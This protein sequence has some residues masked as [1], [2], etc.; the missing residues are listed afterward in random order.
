MR[1]HLR[2]ILVALA[3]AVVAAC[4]G[5]VVVASPT[6]A[7]A[8]QPKMCR[9]HGVV[10]AVCTKCNPALIPVFQAKGDWCAEHGFPESFCPI[11]HPERGGLPGVDTST[12][13][14]PA[15][16]T[17]VRFKTK[18]T[19][20]LAGL[21]TAPARE[22]A[23]QVEVDATIKIVFDAARVA[24]VNARASGVVRSIAA[25]VG[26]TVGVGA[27]LAMVES[28]EVGAERSRQAAARARVELA[29]A[30]L[31]RATS[32]HAQGIAPKRDVLSTRQELEA[33]RADLAS[34]KAALGVVDPGATSGAQYTV[35]APIAGVVTRRDASIGHLVAATDVLFEVVDTSTMWAQIDVPEAALG[36]VAAG[37][38][39]SISLDSLGDREFSG[40]IAYLAPTIDPGTRTAMARVALANPDGVLRANMFGRAKIAVSHN[41]ASV[42]VP[43][44]AVQRA[45]GDVRLVFVRVADDAY[46]ARRV[47]VASRHG[48]EISVRG[49]VAP[50]DLVVTTGSFLLKTET[51]K[52]SIGA[53]CCAGE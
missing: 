1:R 33:A 4:F 42:A 39:V 47:R 9:E 8:A 26:T 53:G 25:D 31:Q 35:T 44:A 7:P 5:E 24:Q 29:D 22:Q 48:D 38:S 32:L 49:R 19:A 40:V 17:M 51:L 21:E 37:Q 2:S 30:N 18:E 20:R 11:C 36:S 13:E 12:D 28:A 46:E 6:S 27:P 3:V 45:P 10:E 16:G 43:A 34:A 15:D 23:E 52:G 14:A 50:G 41:G